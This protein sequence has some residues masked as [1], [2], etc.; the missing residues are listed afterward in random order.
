MATEQPRNVLPLPTDPT[1]HPQGAE[2]VTVKLSPEH[3]AKEIRLYTHTHSPQERLSQL[4][5]GHQASLS[6]FPNSSRNTE[7][8]WNRSEL[9]EASV[10]Y[11]SPPRSNSLIL[12]VLILQRFSEIGTSGQRRQLPSRPARPQKAPASAL[13]LA[14]SD[15]MTFMLCG[16]A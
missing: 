11:L 12:K 8:H 6:A 4:G 14:A 7:G 9:G 13:R 15:C 5:S 1:T 2:S 10:L 3:K 16:E